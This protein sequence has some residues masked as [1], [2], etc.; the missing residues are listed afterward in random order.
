MTAPPK[1]QFCAWCGSPLPYEEHHH[2]PR[3][4]TL[5][6]H[7]RES[8][9]APPPLPD[10]VEDLMRGESYIAACPSCRILSHVISHRAQ[11]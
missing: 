11:G 7:A 2:E 9:E 3:Y 8:G 5:A 4:E 10:R 1:P 6:E